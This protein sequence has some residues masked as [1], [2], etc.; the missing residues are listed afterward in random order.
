MRPRGVCLLTIRLLRYAVE[1]PE[2]LY[3]HANAK[4]ELLVARQVIPL[5]RPTMLHDWSATSSSLVLLEHPLWFQ[6][7]GTSRHLLPE[8]KPAV[9]PG[10]TTHPILYYDTNAPT[11][12][13]IFAKSTPEKVDWFEVEGCAVIHTANAWDEVL[14]GGKVTVLVAPRMKGGVDLRGLSESNVPRRESR[15]T[16]HIWAVDH[17]SGKVYERDLLAE[18]V[19][20]C[21][22]PTIDNRKAGK[23]VN[24]VYAAKISEGGK[25][26]GGFDG[27]CKWEFDWT[28][29]SAMDL[30]QGKIKDPK[31]KTVTYG[32]NKRGGEPVF[33]PRSKEGAEDDG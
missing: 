21:E 8:Y 26:E 4:G 23:R 27:M 12:L 32:G 16:M 29:G 3:Y 25:P 2:I 13:G 33:I 5:R 17:A 30:A 9:D 22:F 31:T 10:M 1:K 20:E 11:R 19:A 15:A 18:K 28:S 14:D 24:V 7:P 6:I